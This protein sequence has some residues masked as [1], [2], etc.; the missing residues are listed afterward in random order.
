MQPYKFIIIISFVLFSS[1]IFSQSANNT[2]L[3]LFY[4]TDRAT[5]DLDI[6]AVEK[7]A[8]EDSQHIYMYIYYINTRIDKSLNKAAPYQCIDNYNS[9][10]YEIS[11]NNYIGDDNEFA[12]NLKNN[13][14]VKYDPI[15]KQPLLYIFCANDSIKSL[16]ENN[17][18]L[19]YLIKVQNDDGV[20][21]YTTNNK[22]DCPEMFC[23]RLNQILDFFENHKEI[24][25]HKSDD[26][27]VEQKI[28]KTIAVNLHSAFPL[29]HSMASSNKMYKN[30]ISMNSIPIFLGLDVQFVK[31]NFSFGLGMFHSKFNFNNS[32]KNTS[33][34]ID[35]SNAN[36]K[37]NN[38]K[39]INFKNVNEMVSF[40]NYNI[41]LPLT[42]SLC[43]NK[44]KSMFFDINSKLIY[45]LPFSMKS[46]LISGEF[47]YR[48]KIEGINDELANIP[49]L[50]FIENN[51][52]I[53]GQESAVKMHGYGFNLGIN[54]RYNYRSFSAKFGLAYYN[55]SYR[56]LQ[57]QSGSYVTKQ[58]NEYQSS[59]FGVKNISSNSLAL[60]FGIGYIIK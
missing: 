21:Y 2:H 19:L 13:K 55:M 10:L 23:W 15:K 43:L 31:K 47:S 30:S 17:L 45:A 54:M 14:G 59:F 41:Y 34:T 28:D 58:I 37:G 48:G 53:V 7:R 11:F 9:E 3:N 6:S 26:L 42:Y 22:I 57:Y 33:Y 40:S 16:I 44:Q 20:K 32:L 36:I 24:L 51:Q 1:L 25:K 8:Q 4:S 49:S 50:G 60:C 38:F 52:S 35:W 5:F 46:K 56:N 27:I 12:I 18:S 29:F 39:A